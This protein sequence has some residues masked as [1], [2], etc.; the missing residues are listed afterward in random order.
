MTVARRGCGGATDGTAF[1]IVTVE[2][3]WCS[4]ALN[5]L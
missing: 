1:S 2:Q 4:S 5:K 3:Q